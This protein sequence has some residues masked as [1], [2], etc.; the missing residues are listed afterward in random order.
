MNERVRTN[1]IKNLHRL[2]ARYV[3]A[4]RS[5]FDRRAI[6]WVILAFLLGA[7]CVWL[8]QKSIG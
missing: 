6:R 1:R 8:I 7:L 4:K 3:Q 5:Q 2:E